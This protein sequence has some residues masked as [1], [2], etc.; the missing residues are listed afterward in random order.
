MV[1]ARNRIA[2]VRL[3]SIVA[4][5]VG[6]AVLYGCGFF[7]GYHQGYREGHHEGA[8]SYVR[9]RFVLKQP[10]ESRREGSSSGRPVGR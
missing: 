6:V 1:T 4:L 9:Q 2:I 3:A 8:Q 10:L 5:L 7:H